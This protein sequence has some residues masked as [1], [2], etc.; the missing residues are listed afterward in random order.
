M[1]D[2]DRSWKDGIAFNALVHRIKPELV[3][4]DRVSRGQPKDNLE[5][6]FH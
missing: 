4:M 1:T 2:L 3:D 6:V 5:Q